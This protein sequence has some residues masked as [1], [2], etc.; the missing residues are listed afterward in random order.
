MMGM[1]LGRPY[2]GPGPVDVGPADII[3][4]RI[5][6]AVNPGTQ[7]GRVTIPIELVALELVSRE[8]VD[9]AP[10]GRSGS[11]RVFL[12]LRSYPG[13]QPDLLALGPPAEGQMTLD[14][15]LRAFEAF[16]NVLFELRAGSPTGPLLY[17]AGDRIETTMP[18]PWSA[19]ARLDAWLLP[20]LNEGFFPK[21]AE[22][23]AAISSATLA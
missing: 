1:P 7:T 13:L 18:V 12:S 4:R 20:G 15:N 23:I 10:F 3:L 17:S 21:V 22:E 6:P 11:D 9:L 14:F 5:A 19:E 16:F 2:L 8:P